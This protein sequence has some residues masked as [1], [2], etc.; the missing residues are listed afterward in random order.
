MEGFQTELRTACSF[1]LLREPI[2]LFCR[3]GEQRRDTEGER[4]RDTVSDER[5]RDRDIETERERER[6]DK[7]H[8]MI[9]VTRMSSCLPLSSFSQK[10]IQT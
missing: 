9:E 3:R 8:V 4:Q 5:V 10:C 7:F 6:D 2:Q 1:C